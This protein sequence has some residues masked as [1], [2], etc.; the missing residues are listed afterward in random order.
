MR[1]TV[2]VLTEPTSEPITLAEARRWLN[3][4]DDDD[5]EQDP[6]IELLIR[7]MRRYAEAYTGRRFCDTELELCLDYFPRV[8]EF[9]VAP[10]IGVDYVRYIDTN[11]ELQSFYDAGSPT[12]GASLVDIDLRS[13]PGRIQPAYGEQWPTIRGGDFNPV[14]IG[15]TAGYGTGGSPED[16]SV[17]PAELKVWMRQRLATLFENREAIIV[18][19]SV[20]EIPRAMHDALLDSLVL[21]RRI[22]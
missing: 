20:N 8:I 17:I 4:T 15:F 12:I 9:P 21:G 16:L 11:G 7:A 10:L 13:R 14:R 19:V 1:S 3:M 2:L 6:E 22:G 18:G 5:T